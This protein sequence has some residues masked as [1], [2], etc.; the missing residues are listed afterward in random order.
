MRSC[1]ELPIYIRI[2]LKM[3][4]KEYIIDDDLEDSSEEI[5]GQN[6]ESEDDDM[7]EKVRKVKNPNA[8]TFLPIP[9]F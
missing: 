8:K 1:V 7:T 2:Q 4:E 3:E 5:D 6:E 9:P